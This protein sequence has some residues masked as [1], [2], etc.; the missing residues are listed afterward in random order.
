MYIG[1]WYREGPS[2]ICVEE[3]NNREEELK[4]EETST[5]LREEGW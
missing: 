2:R 1:V 3:E 5:E 4:E